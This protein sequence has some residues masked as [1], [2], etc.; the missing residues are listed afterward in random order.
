MLNPFKKTAPERSCKDRQARERVEGMRNHARRPDAFRLEP[1]EGEAGRVHPR[2]PEASRAGR[3][4]RRA[5]ARPALEEEPRMNYTCDNCGAWNA[6]V[7]KNC[8]SCGIPRRD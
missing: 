4:G 1:D 3:H 5:A 7:R 6:P 8:R 2:A